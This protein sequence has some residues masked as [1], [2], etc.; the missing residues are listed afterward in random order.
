MREADRLTISAITSAMD[1]GLV[2]F[3]LMWWVLIY[4]L[5]QKNLRS[6]MQKGESTTIGL[7][8]MA[9]GIET[10][11]RTLGMR[12]P[13]LRQ[14]METNGHRG[15]VVGGDRTGLRPLWAG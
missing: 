12:T 8:R 14:T 15:G 7:E 13:T 10:G 1:G 11:L 3:I 2:A 6:W 5:R 9:C 4:G